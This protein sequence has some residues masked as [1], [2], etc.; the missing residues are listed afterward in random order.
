MDVDDRCAVLVLLASRNGAEY[1]PR[2][3]ETLVEQTE[4]S[5]NI[6]V[7]DDNSADDTRDI[8][9]V[10]ARN[11]C[12]IKLWPEHQAT[13]SAAGN[14]FKLIV[15]SDLAKVDYV[16]FCDQDDEW[17]EGKLA[18]AI[19]QLRARGADGYSAG[20]EAF[21]PD[22]SKKQLVQNNRTRF[23]DH[24]FEGA[25]QGCTFVMTKSF[26]ME[27]Q[28]ILSRHRDHLANL[29]YH[30]WTI[31]ALARTLGKKW[32]I[33]DIPTMAYRQH[34]NN[35]TGARGSISGL[36][37][38]VSLIRNGWY[39]RQ[40]DNVTDLMLLVSAGDSAATRWR[41]LSLR[42]QDGLWARLCRFH[43]VMT[44]GRRRFID[45]GVLMLAVVF[46]YL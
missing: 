33:D 4:V 6:M 40:V 21:W 45:R 3:I 11:D 12:R 2:Q 31:Y 25:G 36:R 28:A 41:D 44:K 34:S 43:F 9:S 29:H 30:D 24:L 39:R 46:G 7:R 42:H 10:L 8:V 18:R 32:V 20:V 15:G 26:F 19:S 37:R 14:F 16:A 27:V 22:G 5:V 38:R 35:D 1:L 13:G 17:F 23:A